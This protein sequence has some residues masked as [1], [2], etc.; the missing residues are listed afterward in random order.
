MDKAIADYSTSIRIKPNAPIAYFNRGIIYHQQ[1][2]T[3]K[4]MADYTKAI[5]L[6]PDYDVAYYNRSMIYIAQADNTLACNDLRKAADLGYQPAIES[7]KT[8]C[9]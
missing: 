4:A 6:K 9:K 8:L 5:E 7:V 2:F 1:G 3:E